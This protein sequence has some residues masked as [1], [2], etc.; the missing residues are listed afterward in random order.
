MSVTVVHVCPVLEQRGVG[1]GKHLLL[2]REFPCTPAFKCSAPK[3]G[4][5]LTQKRCPSEMPDCVI[6][7]METALGT[8]GCCPRKVQ[9]TSVSLLLTA[10]AEESVRASRRFSGLTS[11]SRLVIRH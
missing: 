6:S 8:S 11:T 10:R 3:T 4:F 1:A 5:H 7:L 9:H 2:L